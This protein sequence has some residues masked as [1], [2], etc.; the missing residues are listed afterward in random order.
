LLKVELLKSLLILVSKSVQFCIGV[1]KKEFLVTAV[2]FK[3]IIL[4]LMSIE[5]IIANTEKEKMAKVETELKN[6]NALKTMVPHIMVAI[7]KPI[8]FFIDFGFNSDI[9][10]S[11]I[12]SVYFYKY[13]I[14][15]DK[16]QDS[17]IKKGLIYR[18][19]H[20]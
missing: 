14:L 5:T 11:Y 3:G 7:T 9:F 12:N 15:K 19:K 17:N 4:N 1:F 6:E 2:N 16:I 13:R 20:K 8:S 10:S 18:E